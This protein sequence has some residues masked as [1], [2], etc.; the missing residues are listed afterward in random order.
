MLYNRDSIKKFLLSNVDTLIKDGVIAGRVI[1][2]M[3]AKNNKWQNVGGNNK[4]YDHID[5]KGNRI[6]TKSTGSILKDRYMRVNGLLNKKNSCDIIQIIDT[7]AGR[8]FRIPHDVFFGKAILEQGQFWWCRNYN[9]N[10]LSHKKGMN[11]E[12]L[13]EYEV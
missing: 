6:E 11:T 10:I 3:A 12:L 4:S 1:E 13:L 2:Q 7:L 9:P 5:K 8:E